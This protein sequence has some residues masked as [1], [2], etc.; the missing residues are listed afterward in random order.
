MENEEFQTSSM[1]L[2][3]TIFYVKDIVEFMYKGTIYTGKLSKFYNKV[4]INKENLNTVN[5]THVIIIIS[6]LYFLN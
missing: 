2:N 1:Y 5:Y 6:V 3:G 4:Y